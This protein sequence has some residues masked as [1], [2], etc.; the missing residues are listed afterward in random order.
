MHGMPLT[1]TPKHHQLLAIMHARPFQPSEPSQVSASGH[2]A[3]APQKSSQ[4]KSLERQCP[5]QGRSPASAQLIGLCRAQYAPQKYCPGYSE[6]NSSMSCSMW[7]TY[8]SVQPQCRVLPQKIPRRVP[9]GQQPHPDEALPLTAAV[10]LCRG[11]HA[12]R[13]TGTAGPP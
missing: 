9:R 11:Q 10:R 8:I 13:H 6:R 12:P 3:V 1:L 7:R 5:A 4:A 2:F